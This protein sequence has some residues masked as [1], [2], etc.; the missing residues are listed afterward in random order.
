MSFLISFIALV[1]VN[2]WLPTP[3][4]ATSKDHQSI[5]CPQLNFGQGEEKKEYKVLATEGYQILICVPPK[6]VNQGQLTREHLFQYEA[7]LFKK[8]RFLRSLFSG[9]SKTAT[10]FERRKGIVYEISH[11]NLFEKFYPLFETEVRC[12]NDNCQKGKKTCVFRQG[13]QPAMSPSDF[14]IEKELIQKVQAR[15]QE[16]VTQDI[17]NFLQYALKGREKAIAFFTRMELLPKMDSNSLT[18]YKNIQKVI[19]TMIIEDCLTPV[20]EVQS[21]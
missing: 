16:L 3:V 11:L 19:E 9:N 10:A 20:K 8:D 18:V 1:F 6:D 17:F 13:L 15:E 14:E 4:A 5:R 7:Y 21:N 2:F 12:K